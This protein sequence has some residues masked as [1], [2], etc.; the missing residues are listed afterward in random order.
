MLSEKKL[1][2]KWYEGGVWHGQKY[3]TLKSD[4]PGFCMEPLFNM[5]V[6]R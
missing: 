1:Y 2:A 6:K 5:C 3:I 4:R